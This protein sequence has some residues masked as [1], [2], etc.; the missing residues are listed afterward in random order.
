MVVG[1][2]LVVGFCAVAPVYPYTVTAFPVHLAGLCRGWVVFT[3][4]LCFVLRFGFLLSS[5]VPIARVH[6]SVVAALSQSLQLCF[7]CSS[8]TGLRGRC[9]GVVLVS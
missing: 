2:L 4:M 5:H 6:S 7:L 8:S 1:S 9:V 3:N